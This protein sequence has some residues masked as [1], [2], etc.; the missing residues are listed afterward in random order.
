MRLFVEN[1]Q[2]LQCT[3]HK[4]FRTKAKPFRLWPFYG[5]HFLFWLTQ[6]TFLRLTYRYSGETEDCQITQLTLGLCIFLPSKTRPPARVSQ[7]FYDRRRSLA[8]CINKTFCNYHTFSILWKIFDALF[9]A[10][11]Q[12]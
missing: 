7:H 4:V 10:I 8:I 11:P 1:S 3:S 5:G 6:Q 9:S 2:S 12:T